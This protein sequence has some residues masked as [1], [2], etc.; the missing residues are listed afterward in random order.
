[1]WDVGLPNIFNFVNSPHQGD[2]PLADHRLVFEFLKASRGNPFCKNVYNL[3]IGRHMPNTN[4]FADNFVTNVMLIDFNMFRP[5]M[6]NRIRCQ[7]YVTNVVTPNDW[8]VRE[9]NMKVALKFLNLGNLCSSN[10]KRTI[11]GFY[12]GVRDSGLLFETPRDDIGT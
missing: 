1:M 8:S 12:A 10:G 9:K 5:G 3:V 4:L 2:R 7:G 6:E 11:F